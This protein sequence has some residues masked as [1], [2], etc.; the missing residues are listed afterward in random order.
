MS[1]S[2]TMFWRRLFRKEG[3]REGRNE[4]QGRNEKKNIFGTIL[5]ARRDDKYPLIGESHASA[6]DNKLKESHVY[7]WK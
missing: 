3:M 1:R 7:I 6:A 2:V 4:I 5:S